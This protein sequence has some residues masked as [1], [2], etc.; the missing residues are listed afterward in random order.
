MRLLEHLPRHVAEN[1]NRMIAENLLSKRE[2]AFFTDKRLFDFWSKARKW[3]ELQ[4]DQFDA[5]E[6]FIGV[7]LTPL[8]LYGEVGDT[9]NKSPKTEMIKHQRK[10]DE[11]ID[12]AYTL[13]DKL[14]NVLI[15]LEKTSPYLQYKSRL[16]PI[17][18]QLIPSLK[19]VNIA[20]Y[21]EGIKTHEA[22]SILKESLVNSPVTDDIFEGV[23]GMESQKSTPHDWHR[24]AEKSLARMLEKF[25]N[26]SFTLT[27]AEWSLLADVLL[28]RALVFRGESIYNSDKPLKA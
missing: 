2:N 22:L 10:A 27:Q 17:A 18:R 3:L 19:D 26:G 13:A 15:E 6:N 4:A 5:G 8:K 1:Y 16:L 9:Q 12:E 23:A 11:L 20:S 25:P 24:E 14:A 21:Y 7:F 28:D